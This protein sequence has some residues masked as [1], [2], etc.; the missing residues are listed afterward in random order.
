M[1]CRITKV[2]YT[3]FTFEK[4]EGTIKKQSRE[5]GNIGYTRG[6]KQNRSTTKDVLDTTM[7]KQ[8]QIT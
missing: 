7:R 2:K 5:T 4:T 8:T 6:K 1:L 3:K